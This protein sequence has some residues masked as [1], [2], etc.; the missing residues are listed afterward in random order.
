VY[1]QFKVVFVIPNISSPE[2]AKIALRINALHK[3]P[4]Q[5]QG[6]VKALLL[7]A[8]LARLLFWL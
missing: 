5:V 3:P 6:S 8:S 1:T 2:I 4:P 7:V